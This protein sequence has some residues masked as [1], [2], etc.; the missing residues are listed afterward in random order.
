MRTSLRAWCPVP[1][2]LLTVE[3]VAGDFPAALVDD[4]PV[5][6]GPI[7]PVLRV[8]EVQIPVGRAAGQ[9]PRD[10]GGQAGIGGGDQLP[11]FGVGDLAQ[12]ALGGTGIGQGGVGP[13]QD[14]LG[15]L[16]GHAEAVPAV[17]GAL[18]RPQRRDGLTPVPGVGQQAAHDRG[19]HPAA[20]VSGPGGDGGH[21]AE[22]QDGSAGHRHPEGQGAARARPSPPPR[23]RPG[24]G[25]TRRASSRSPRP[26]GAGRSRK[27]TRAPGPR[28]STRR[29]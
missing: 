29:A 26:R 3:G 25:R 17:D 15:T 20:A 6:G 7:A 14:Q 22:G 23:R 21:P 4:V 5:G 12:A 9:G 1:R 16:D 19:E 18:R 2:L 10:A 11:G 24:S 27:P 28:P 13:F 8:E